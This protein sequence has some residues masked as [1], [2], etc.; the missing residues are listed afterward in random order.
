MAV[1]AHQPSAPPPSAATATAGSSSLSIA[2]QEQHLTDM[3]H[4]LS[5]PSHQQQGTSTF[6]QNYGPVKIVD[7]PPS[8]VF[9]MRELQNGPYQPLTQRTLQHAANLM[10]NPQHRSHR[11]KSLANATA[12]SLTEFYKKING[13]HGVAASDDPAG[14]VHKWMV[15]NNRRGVSNRLS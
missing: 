4:T 1:P 5:L 7:Q 10:H 3:A 9:V 13:Q 15:Q 8:L 11:Q 12:K 14:D 6:V 2:Q